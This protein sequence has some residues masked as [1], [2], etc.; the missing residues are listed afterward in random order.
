MVPMISP[1]LTFS[2]SFFSHSS[3]VPSS[4]PSPI[5]G[6]ITSVIPF[7]SLLFLNSDYLSMASS[8]VHGPRESGPGGE[9]QVRVAEHCRKRPGK[10]NCKG[11]DRLR[12]L[13]LAAPLPSCRHSLDHLQG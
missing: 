12:S 1:L 11:C 3:S 13:D 5:L 10:C 2:P 7:D 8:Q 6:M 4:I 9:V